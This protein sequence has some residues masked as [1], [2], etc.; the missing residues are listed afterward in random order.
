MAG[1]LEELLGF[2]SSPSRQVSLDSYSYFLSILGHGGLRSLSPLLQVKASAVD[3]VRGLTG[4]DDGLETLASRSDLTLLPLLRLLGDHSDISCPA[5]DALINLSQNPTMAEKLVSLRAVDDAMEVIYKPDGADAR[6]SRLLVMLLAN[7]TQSDSG[8][9]SL[10]QDT[11]E[12]VASVL[13]NVSKVEAGRRILL[14]PKGSL[15]K[16]IIRQSDS[17]NP[18]RKKGVSG[19][20]RN[21][22]FEAD[23]QLHNLLSLSEYLWPAL[24]LPVA[25]KKAYSEQD[26]TKMPPELS[27]ALSH[28]REPV[29]DPE[30]RKQAL[31]TLYLIV[32]QNAG[33]SALWSVNGPRILQVGYEDEEDPKVMEAYEL[34]GSLVN[35]SLTHNS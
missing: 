19:T 33:R 29:H 2:L 20:I 28:E 8:I 34:V 1:E 31:E 30:I 35:Y 32:L 12:H 17:T 5:A 25:G 4:S 9:A 13:V 18:L 27:N 16:Q 22:C 26:M 21:C 10:L 24:L 7:L 15:L 14:Q 23:K 6:L 3:I 11:F